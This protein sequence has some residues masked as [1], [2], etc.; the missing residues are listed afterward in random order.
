MLLAASCHHYYAH[1]SA[2]SQGGL[3][4]IDAEVALDLVLGWL[5]DIAESSEKFREPQTEDR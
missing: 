5:E 4:R 3:A 2:C 1:R